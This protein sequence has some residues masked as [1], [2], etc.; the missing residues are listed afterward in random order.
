MV[1][2]HLVHSESHCTSAATSEPSREV[3]TICETENVTLQHGRLRNHANLHQAITCRDL[4]GDGRRMEYTKSGRVKPLDPSTLRECVMG[5]S[6]PTQANGETRHHRRQTGILE[7]ER[8]GGTASCEQR[9]LSWHVLHRASVSREN[10]KWSRF[11]SLQA[12]Q[13]PDQRRRGT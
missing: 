13:R 5:A 3:W 4:T 1:T 12:R 9:R 8:Q 2:W 6:G 7:V 10:A 11:A